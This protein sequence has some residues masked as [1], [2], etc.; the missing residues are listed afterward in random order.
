VKKYSDIIPHFTGFLREGELGSKRYWLE[1]RL[2]KKE[3]DNKGRDGVRETQIKWR[4]D[5]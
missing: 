4:G 1:E 3:R 2:R 5:G